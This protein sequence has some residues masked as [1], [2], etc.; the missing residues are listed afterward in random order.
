MAMSF[1]TKT[2]SQLL[3]NRPADRPETTGYLL[4]EI[5][6]GCGEGAT[7]ETFEAPSLF[8][9]LNRQVDMYILLVM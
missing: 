8:S 6:T 3:E 5:M 7:H 9:R 4:G 2:V 1:I